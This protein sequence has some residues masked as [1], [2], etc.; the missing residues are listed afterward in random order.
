MSV[1]TAC[2]YDQPSNRRRNPGHQYI[3]AV[4][5]R[6]HKAEA[7]LQALLP[8]LDLDDPR[9]DTCTVSDLLSHFKK[10]RNDRTPGES[11]QPSPDSTGV[12]DD[13]EPADES[14]LESMVDHSGAL[15]LDDQGHWDYHGHSSGLMFMRRLKKQFGNIGP[16]P[17]PKFPPSYSLL[18]SKSCSESPADSEAS[19][20]ADLPSRE[21]ALELCRH[22]VEEACAVF[23]FLHKPTFYA[24]FNR[25]YEIPSDQYTNKEHTFL[26]LLYLSLAVGCLFGDYAFDKSGY[27]SA[28]DQGYQFYRA[29]RQLLDVTE[30]RDLT[31][32]QSI[33]M[34]VVFLQNSANISTCYSYVGIALRAAVRLGL[35]RSIP[36][37][38]NPVEQETRKRVFWMVRKLDVHISVILGLPSMLVDDD[39]DQEYPLEVDDEFITPT[40]ILPMPPNYTPLMSGILAHLRLGRIMTKVTKYVYPVKTADIGSNHSYMVRHSKIREIESD[41]QAWF[42]ALPDTFKPG[43]DTKPEIERYVY[44]CII[45]TFI[46]NIDDL[47]YDRGSGSPMPMCK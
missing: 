35:H 3:E 45:L 31:S 39:I 34:M 11:T 7:I 24:M 26:P 15:D 17:A 19:A 40:A 13:R 20:L 33:C 14:L 30:C 23:C 27:K 37:K 18:E 5:A 21:L 22:A 47:D 42:L 32:L 8:N 16:E 43:G 4:E 25:I 28:T 1:P 36:Q 44:L 9:I 2:T 10:D 38:F 41:L 46:A 6:L 12:P 29:G